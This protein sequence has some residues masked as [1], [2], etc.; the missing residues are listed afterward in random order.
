MSDVLQKVCDHFDLGVLHAS[1]IMLGGRSHDVRQLKTDRGVFIAK[2]LLEHGNQPLNLDVLRNTA[3]ISLVVKKHGLPAITPLVKNNDVLF[4]QAQ[5]VYMVYPFV[6]ARVVQRG[7]MSVAQCCDVAVFLA[8]LH[9]LNLSVPAAAKWDYHYQG[10]NWKQ[11]YDYFMQAH[12]FSIAPLLERL[13]ATIRSCFSNYIAFKSAI[14]SDVVVSHRDVDPYNVLWFLSGDYAVIDW[15]LA[16]KIDAAEELMY[17]AMGFAREADNQ[18][19]IAKFTAILQS[20]SAVRP[21]KTQEVKPLFYAVLANWL[22]WCQGQL[23][24][25]MHAQF[26]LATLNAITLGVRRS[27]L[28]TEYML[29]I[30]SE[31]E[32]AWSAALFGGSIAK[33]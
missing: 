2:R 11:A 5:N 23:H 21:I 6:A 18:F 16:G 29:S 28:T 22:A 19:N 26:D 12:L 3:A 15:D 13:N 24:K 8:K 10:T 4:N 14:V 1:S 31:I 27:L 20:Y 9:N 33:K 25:V 17:V 32:Q 30:E 7:V